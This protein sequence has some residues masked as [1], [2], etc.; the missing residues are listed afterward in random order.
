MQQYGF[1]DLCIPVI[2][3]PIGRPM[4]RARAEFPH[5]TRPPGR[6]RSPSAPNRERPR[7]SRPNTSPSRPFGEAAL[8]PLPQPTNCSIHGFRQPSG[9]ASPTHQLFNSRFQTTQRTDD[10]AIVPRV[11]KIGSHQHYSRTSPSFIKSLFK[12][13]MRQ[14]H[15]IKQPGR[16]SHSRKLNDF[17]P[18]N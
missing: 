16:Q 3:P 8:L 1:I 6:A 12:L 11:S 14:L 17:I 7:L 5:A 4:S 2:K 9:P 13:K 10:N 15:H 18:E